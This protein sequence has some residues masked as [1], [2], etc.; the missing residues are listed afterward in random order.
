MK[1]AIRSHLVNAWTWAECRQSASSGD[2]WLAAFGSDLWA[3]AA[4]YELRTICLPVDFADDERSV[5]HKLVPAGAVGLSS[6]IQGSTRT[7]FRD[8]GRVGPRI[9]RQSL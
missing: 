4:P 5:L 1:A 3:M 2:G 6:R 7:P 9:L 8:S